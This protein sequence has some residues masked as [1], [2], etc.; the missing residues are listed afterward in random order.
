MEFSQIRCFLAVADTLHFTRAAEQVHLSQPALSSQI[1][2][3]ESHLGVRLFERSHLKTTLTFAG[4][5]FREDAVRIME[6][7]ARATE[8]A[9]QAAEGRI[10][11][12]RIGFIS[13]AAGHMIP[14]LVAAFQQSHPD[15]E[16]K[17]T[18]RLT[19]EQVELLNQRAIDIGFA[20]IPLSEAQRANLT[21]VPVHR[22]PFKL[23]LP[24]DHPLAMRPHVEMRDLDGADF[25]TYS[26][27]NA[28]GFAAAMSQIL[29]KESIRPSS[30]HE[31]SDM[32]TLISLVS[33][34]VGVA[35]APASLENYRLPDVVIRNLEGVR[36]SEIGMLY[37]DDL[38]HPTALA[39]M[40]MAKTALTGED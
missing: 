17:L 31:A 37:R 13:T 26:K 35:I 23:F 6:G 18:H 8:R 38:D 40:R 28:P 32:Y 21:V 27:R 11:R 33:A 36:P 15:I 4:T 20:R 24:S 9:R 12:V 7:A 30:T 25:V 2:Q 10:G 14:S 29:T 39:F 3:L 19:A 34:G 5:V 22:E 1:R 16:L